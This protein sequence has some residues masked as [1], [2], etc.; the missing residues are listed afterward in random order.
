MG[1]KPASTSGS[2]SDPSAALP[3]R[4]IGP[5]YPPTLLGWTRRI[6]RGQLS[7]LLRLVAAVRVENLPDF[8]ALGPVILAPNHTSYLD[9]PLL[10]Q[11]VP[12]H[13]TFLMTETIYRHPRFNWFFRFWGTLPVPESGRA[14]SAI[15]GA[16]AALADGRPV[17]I[18][19]EGRIAE[20]GFLQDAQAGV[21]LLMVKAGVPVIP[22]GLNGI[23]AVLP[24]HARWPRR[25][26]V[27]V[28]FGEPLH[29]PS[30]PL[31]RDAMQ[32][33]ARTIMDAIARLG[34]PRRPAEVTQ[35]VG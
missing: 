2:D 24:K 18:F 9:P 29:P 30:G 33:F 14:V 12:W 26:R 20:D 13:V 32:Q 3:P 6:V 11:A 31:D 15:R 27:T 28:R 23:Y 22:V 8:R 25:G 17:V 19:P 1:L 35:P 10:Q 16:V 21:V 7:L 34:P 5:P 4:A